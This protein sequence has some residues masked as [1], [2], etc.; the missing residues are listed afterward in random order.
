MLDVDSAVL[1]VIDVQEKLARVICGRE[2]LV[3]NLQKL[4]VGIQVLGVPLIITEQYP[5]GLG[6]TLPEVARCIPNVQPLPKLSFSCLGDENIKR[7]IE[8]TGRRQVIVSGIESHVCV[9]QTVRDLIEQK[10]EVYVVAD[11]VSSRTEENRD[12][13]LNL[14]Q[15]MGAFCSSTETVLFELLK[16]AE[17]E[18]FKKISRIVK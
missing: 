3:A 13:G 5:R 10:Y 4:I 1:L 9:Y 12:I 8:A 18:R 16:I 11:A 6:E 7:K 15:Q 17:G 14:M 2:R